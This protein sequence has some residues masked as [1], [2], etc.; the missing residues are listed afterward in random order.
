MSL[1]SGGEDADQM[2]RLF[3]TENVGFMLVKD[4][5][6]AWHQGVDSAIDFDRS[7]ACHTETAFLMI[8]VLQAGAATSGY[9]SFG[10]GI[11]QPIILG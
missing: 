10:E 9:D 4:V 5:S 3:G 11:A 1:E 6:N 8:F 7:L 2:Q